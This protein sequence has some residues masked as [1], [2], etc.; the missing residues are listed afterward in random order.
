MSGGRIGV[1]VEDNGS[2]TP[3]KVQCNGDFS[4]AAEVQIVAAD[5]GSGDGGAGDWSE[6]GLLQQLQQLLQVID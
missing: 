3:F 2:D 4:W 5:G 1:I 6:F